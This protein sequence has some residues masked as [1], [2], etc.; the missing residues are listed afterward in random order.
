MLEKK[1]IEIMQ[2]YE[3][4]MRDLEL[5]RD[6]NLPNGCIAAGYVR[7][8]VWDDLHGYHFRTPLN[9]VDVL[10][11]DPDDLKEETEQNYETQLKAE[12]KEYNWSVKNQARMHLRNGDEPYLSVADA[13]KRWP[14]VVTAV[15]ISLDGDGN[16]QV[17]A[18]HG[19]QDLFDLVVRRSPYFRDED[20]FRSRMREKKWL[21]RWPRLKLIEEGE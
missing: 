14:E 3:Y 4:F 11:F 18:P 13:M 16:I 15:G 10:Y 8:Y 20:V 2:T 6:L 1:L 21:E 19:L 17:T 9:D 12:V 5:L 7:N